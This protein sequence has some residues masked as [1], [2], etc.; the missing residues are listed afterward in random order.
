MNT[1]RL[2]M[3]LLSS[4][5]FSACMDAP[6]TSSDS[7]DPA[8]T[9][10]HNEVLTPYQPLLQRVFN[11]AN[12]GAA[13][14]QLT[15]EDRTIVDHATQPY[16]DPDT[17]FEIAPVDDAEGTES[18]DAHADALQARFSGC[19]ALHFTGARKAILGNTLYTYWQNTNVCV[20]GGK[21][22]KVSVTNAGGETRTLGWRITHEPTTS[23][24]NAGWEGRGKAQYY[25]VLGV[26]GW[27]IQ[28]PSDCLQ[29]R[30]N[31]DG[32]HYRVM[33]SC[34]LQAN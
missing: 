33:T 20:S 17:H 28:H 9:T 16:G 30:L 34:D 8:A 1:M 21:V 5:G 27:D 23:T 6:G 12:P 4:I 29:G 11:A 13:Y 2:M 15:A 3:V 22:T 10:N 32:S 26:G 14:E 19:W 18:T 24:Y 25:F 31:A 7:N